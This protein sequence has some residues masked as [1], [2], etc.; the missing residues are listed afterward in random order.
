MVWSTL[1][2]CKEYTVRWDSLVIF[3]QNYVSNFYIHGLDLFKTPLLLILELRIWFVNIWSWCN[4]FDYL[5]RSII[6]AFVLLVSFEV[7]PSF[8]KNT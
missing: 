2:S 3:N 8:S 7:C 4:L 1:I 5:D 6:D